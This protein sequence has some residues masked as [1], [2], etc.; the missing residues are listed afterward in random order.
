MSSRPFGEH[1]GANA[2]KQAIY[3]RVLLEAQEGQYSEALA[4]FDVL[5]KMTTINDDDPAA[6]LVG[7]INEV[8]AGSHDVAV[9]GA[10]AADE[11]LW[12]HALFRHHFGFDAINGS[13][14]R[15]ILRCDQQEVES[16]INDKAEWTVP[17]KFSNCRIYVIGTSGTTFKFLEITH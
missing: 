17:E 6:M 13:L 5:K 14:D 9:P 16:T 2:K 4:W 3:N 10:I 8:V 1:L 12:D 11:T 7:K 15:F